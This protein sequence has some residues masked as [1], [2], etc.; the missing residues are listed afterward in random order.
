MKSALKKLI[1]IGAIIAVLGAFALVDVVIRSSY[2]IEFVSVTRL[3]EEGKEREDLPL[4]CGITDGTTNVRFVIRVSRGNKRVEGHTLYIK[5]NRNVLSR[6]VTDENGEVVIDYRCY[7]TVDP[8]KVEPVTL[9]VRDES[10]SVFIFVPA[11]ESYV[12]QMALGESGP[13]SSMT[14]NDIFYDIGD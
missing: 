5:T 10:N 1:V 6:L 2:K 3:E 14:T 8:A 4:N 13:Q 12:L 7:R 9:S 11:E